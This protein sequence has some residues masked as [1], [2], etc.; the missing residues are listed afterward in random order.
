MHDQFFLSVT[1]LALIMYTQTCFDP[2]KLE[3]N[4]DIVFTLAKKLIFEH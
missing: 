2:I 3:A 4:H 1:L